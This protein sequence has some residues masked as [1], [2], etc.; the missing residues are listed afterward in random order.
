MQLPSAAKS[1]REALQGLDEKKF[2]RNQSSPDWMSDLVVFAPSVSV[3]EL[4]TGRNR[5]RFASVTGLVRPSS[6]VF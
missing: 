2:R 6:A 4:G 5:Q 3:D 1:P